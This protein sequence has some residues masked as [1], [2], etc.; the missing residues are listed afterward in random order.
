MELMKRRLEEIK[1]V[2]K[3]QDIEPPG[4]SPSVMFNFDRMGQG[5][6]I[7]TAAASGLRASAASKYSKGWSKMELH[8]RKGEF[9]IDAEPKKLFPS[10]FHIRS[11][12]SDGSL[13]AL[14]RD[15]IA[16]F[17]EALKKKKA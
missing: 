4:L 7:N 8:D 5:H 1:G 3:I 17:L 16:I 6:L 14:A 13:P 15:R 12:R 11:T 2:R 10:L 9:I